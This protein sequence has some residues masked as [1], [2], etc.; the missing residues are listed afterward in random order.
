M[1]YDPISGQFQTGAE[2]YD[3]P[4]ASVGM[5]M[6]GMD[7]VG[8]DIPLAFRMMENLPGITA[9]AMFNSRRFANTMFQGGFLDVANANP[10]NL[11]KF[12]Q[13]RQSR[14]VARAQ[15]FGAYV[16]DVAERPTSAKSFLFGKYR[17]ADK[18]K[19]ST[20][21][22][23]ASRI[24]NASLRP[25]IFNRFSSVTALSGMPNQG[26]YTPFQ[27]TGVLNPLAEKTGLRK[28]MIARGTIDA[29]DD[30]PLFSGGVLGRMSTMSRTYALEQKQAR[31]V[32]K[33]SS[34]VGTRSGERAA[35][36]VANIGKTLGGLD[37]NLARLGTSPTAVG[38]ANIAL[39]ARTASAPTAGLGYFA[40]PGM[41]YGHT[42]MTNLAGSAGTSR[43]K[44]VSDTSRGVLTRR[45]TEY[46]GSALD[47]SQF[48]GTRAFAALESNIGRA[49]MG[50][51]AGPVNPA[52]SAKIG[53]FLAGETV[54]DF[55]KFGVKSLAKLSGQA[56]SQGQRAVGGKLAAKAGTRAL[57]LAL[58][59]L[60]VIGTA[61]LVYDLTKLA[62]QA[63]V[64]AGN[65]A[66]DAVKSMQGSL[67]KPLFGMGFKD[68]EVAAT[69]RA[70]GVMAIQNSRLNARSMLGAEAS[71][72]AAHF[73]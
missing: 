43:L 28:K 59:G 16:G 1:A 9:S 20:Q 63:F 23:K 65:F 18:L 19:S 70:R 69:S 3:A 25:R 31:L 56:F 38:R 41:G 6:Q 8:A 12:G 53:Q 29:A 52:T 10:Q 7:M 15:K 35:A 73:G 27:G 47:P 26:F 5:A 32:A 4:T 13:A 40:P 50:N 36:K 11:T 64:S 57:G 48:K 45:M 14:K 61:A 46:F 22:F 54:D 17:N 68:N 30:S 66:K 71:M 72:M 42:P 33:S 55:G 60:N 58:P 37:T 39:A 2:A 24:N 44:A 49:V 21:F 51:A 62:G 34:N 67:H